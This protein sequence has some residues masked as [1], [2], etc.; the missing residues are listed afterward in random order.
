MFS[1]I[2]ELP[3]PTII[4]FIIPAVGALLKGRAAKKYKEGVEVMVTVVKKL[5]DKTVANAVNLATNKDGIKTLA[6]AGISA[7]VKA[8]DANVLEK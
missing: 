3:W 4:A 6:G 8:L 7:V 1:W 5:N 2:L